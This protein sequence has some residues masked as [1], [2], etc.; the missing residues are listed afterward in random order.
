MSLPNGYE[1]IASAC[2][3]LG[4]RRRT[5]EDSFLV[6]NLSRGTRSESDGT[7]RFSSGHQGCLFAVADGMGGAAAGAMASRICLETLLDEVITMI[8]GARIL[9]I[10]DVERILIEAVGSANRRVFDIGCSRQ[11]YVGMG[12]TLT[13][14]FEL[15][16]S[17]VI[18]QVGDS[19]AYL[20]REEG[21]RQLTRDQSLVGE[22]V[23]RGEITEREARGHPER[24]VLLQAL[25]VRS[26]VELSLKNAAVHPGDILLLCSD[27]LHSQVSADEICEIVRASRSTAKACTELTRLANNRGGPDN[28]TSVI[29]EF[30]PSSD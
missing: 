7:M 8:Q 14:A 19:R 28:I 26:S 17:L 16:G 29:A 18:G 25:G 12:T 15:A 24:S 2:S 20:V 5:N 6:A 1:V 10:G 3:D 27:G 4:R 30:L 11:E 23:S 22:M 13:A 21:I 9:G